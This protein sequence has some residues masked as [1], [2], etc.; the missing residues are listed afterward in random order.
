MT[1]QPNTPQT[2]DEC[3]TIFAVSSAKSKVSKTSFAE[4][5]CLNLENCAERFFGFDL[6]WLG[7]LTEESSVGGAVSKRAPCNEVFPGNVATRYF[8]K[9]VSG[10]DH[11]VETAKPVPQTAKD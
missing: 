6:N 9:L 7:P 2:S 11:Y 5:D 1:K 8:A 4:Q 10:L 3:A